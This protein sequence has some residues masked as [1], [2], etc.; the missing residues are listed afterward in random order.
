MKAVE[1]G[2]DVLLFSNTANYR[3]GPRRRGAR[4]PRERGQRRSGVHGPDRGELCANCRPEAADRRLGTGLTG[5]RFEPKRPSMGASEVAARH[6]RWTVAYG[7]IGG[8][9][10]CSFR[11]CTSA[12]GRRGS[13][14]SSISCAGTMPTRSIS[15]ATSSMAGGSPRPGTGRPSTTRFVAGP[16]RQGQCR[17]QGRLPAGQSR[18]V[19]ARV[20][21]HLFRRGRVRRSHRAHH[22]A[23]Q[24][25]SR[26]PRRPVRRRGA[27]RQ[28]ARPCRRLG[29][30]RRAAHQP[31]HQLGAPPARA[32]RTGR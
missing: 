13:G 23:G 21:R 28:V 5:L 15:S 25:L 18:R 11:T 9:G 8:C 12:C 16:A 32:S 22:G 3:A 30:S 31:R 10:H 4:H 24:D 1:A 14:C 27:T 7:N 29:L 17:H 26:H 2:M 20:S 19:P 6:A